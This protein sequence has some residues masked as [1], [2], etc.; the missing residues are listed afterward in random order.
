M[1][2]VAVIMGKM[3]SGGKKNLVMEYYRNIDRSKVQFD[4][5]CDEDS[6][7]IPVDEIERL[8]G[9]VYIVAPYQH[10]VRNLKDIKKILKENNYK[11]VH[12]YNGTMNVFSMFI[13]KCCGVPVRVNE[14]ISMAHNADKKTYI[15]NIL[16]PFS[17]CFCTH[18]MANGE[19]CGRWQFGDKA[20]EEGKV[21]VFK[22]VVNTEKNC[23]D[24]QLR[25]KCREEFGLKDNIVIG[26]IGRLTE[27]KNTLFIIDIFKEISKREEK[28]KLLIIGDG[29]L[30]EEM[31]K[32]IK[33]YGLD[34]KVLY[35]GRREDIHQFYN[36]MDCFVLPSLYE[37]LPVVGV[38]AECHGLPMFYSTE[39]PKESSIS[40]DTGVF[41]ELGLG[42]KKWAEIVLEKT[43]SNMTVRCDQR[44]KAKMAG[45]DSEEEGIKLTNWYESQ[46]DFLKPGFSGM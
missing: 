7:A 6:N 41:L 39:I 17:K 24:E 14:S 33:S 16:K 37:G 22:T 42:A 11:I 30:R 34:D 38:E 31:L 32:K 40:E 26:H 15:K 45:F 36:A 4:F 5:I 44:E 29:N 28:A 19:E 20:F 13:A 12:G 1:I 10:I 2:R 21:A 25:E 23:F 9:R 27:Q 18:Y 35:L 8:G 3:H 43:K 46:F